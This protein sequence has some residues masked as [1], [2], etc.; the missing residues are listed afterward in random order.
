[1]DRRNEPAQGCRYIE[2]FSSGVR[3][4]AHPRGR[5]SRHESQEEQADT[6]LQV[7]G[8]GRG[9]DLAQY[10]L[11]V[12]VLQPDFC[13]HRVRPLVGGEGELPG[14]QPPRPLF[15]KDGVPLDDQVAQ[16]DVRQDDRVPLAGP[17]LLRGDDLTTEERHPLSRGSGWTGWSRISLGATNSV[18]AARITAS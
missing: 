9:K 3:R 13:G 16:I 12:G 8:T 15:R 11:A 4:K 5:S 2:G 1:M 17:G 14:Q 6:I 7:D 18:S 10:S